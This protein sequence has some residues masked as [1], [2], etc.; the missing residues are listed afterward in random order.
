MAPPEPT[1]VS[2][3]ELVRTIEKEYVCL[4][5]LDRISMPPHSKGGFGR[6]ARAQFPGHDSKMT[7]ALVG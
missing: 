1:I 7:R 2:L 6:V 3:I 5:L 4:G